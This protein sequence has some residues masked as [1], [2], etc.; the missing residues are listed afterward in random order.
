MTCR[1]FSS[2]QALVNLISCS[3]QIHT[4][5]VKREDKLSDILLPVWYAHETKPTTYT[6]ILEEYFRFGTLS[7]VTRPQP[8]RRLQGEMSASVRLAGKLPVQY[9]AKIQSVCNTH[10]EMIGNKVL[11]REAWRRLLLAIL[12]SVKKVN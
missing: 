11:F 3:I 7:S 2:T 5:W 4:Q 8:Q 6:L 10:G 9:V 12:T 1:A